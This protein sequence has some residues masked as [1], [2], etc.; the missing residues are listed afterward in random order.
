MVSIRNYKEHRMNFTIIAL[1]ANKFQHL[2]GADSEVLSQCGVQRVIVDSNPGYPCRVSLQD[3][4][5]GESVLLMNFEH[6][7][8]KTPFRSS[9]AIFVREWADQSRPDTNTVPRMLRHRLLSVRGFDTSGM[10]VDGDVTDGEHLESLVEKLF[11]NPS[12]ANLH[13]HYAKFG[14]YAAMITRQ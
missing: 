6:Q 7:P 5:V 9:H 14:C 2:Y 8:A 1:G 12:V 3:A 13:V 4:N 10:I 11:K